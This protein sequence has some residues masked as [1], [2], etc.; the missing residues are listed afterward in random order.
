LR[1]SALWQSEQYADKN[2]FIWSKFDAVTVCSQQPRNSKQARALSIERQMSIDFRSA[3]V[4]FFHS[5]AERKTTTKGRKMLSIWFAFVHAMQLQLAIIVRMPI[6]KKR[7]RENIFYNVALD[8]G[9]PHAS[10]IVNPNG[11]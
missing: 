10:K 5:F 7:L 1:S 9:Q 6:G 11:L 3:K 4:P 2:E 8:V